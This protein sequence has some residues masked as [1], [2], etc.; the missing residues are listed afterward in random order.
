MLSLTNFISRTDGVLELS[1]AAAF[2][3]ALAPAHL[4]TSRIAAAYISVHDGCPIIEVSHFD[5]K[6][7]VRSHLLAL[8]TMERVNVCTDPFGSRVAVFQGRAIYIFAENQ[9]E[10]QFEFPEPIEQFVFSSIEALVIKSGSRLFRWEPGLREPYLLLDRIQRAHLGEHTVV[11]DEVGEVKIAQIHS[12]EIVWE[13][14]PDVQIP[15]GARACLTC[16]KY[17]LYVLAEGPHRRG[18]REI[19][20]YRKDFGISNAI[21]LFFGEVTDLIG[22]DFAAQTFPWTAG[23]VLM[24]AEIE[25]YPRAWLLGF[26]QTPQAISPESIEVFQVAP[27]VQT[28][29][30]ALVGSDISRPDQSTIRH[31]I[32]AKSKEGSWENSKLESGCFLLPK[33]LDRAHLLYARD[34]GEDYQWTIAVRNVEQIAPNVST[35]VSHLC[36]LARSDDDGVI[37]TVIQPRSHLANTAAILYVQ[38]PHRQITEGAQDTFFHQWLFLVAIKTS[39]PAVTVIGVNGPGSLGLGA[40]TREPSGH[41]SMLVTR[42][43]KAIEAVITSLHRHGIDQIGI[44]CGSLGALPVLQY[45]TVAQ[46]PIAVCFVSPIISASGALASHWQQLISAKDFLKDPPKLPRGTRL[47]LIHGEYDEFTSVEDCVGFIRRLPP[48]VSSDF[49]LLSEEGHVF[50]NSASWK[51][52]AT[53]SRVFFSRAFA[54]MAT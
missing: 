43:E 27:C 53:R 15:N 46:H 33:W 31:L 48:D 26:E 11:V 28:G 21:R 47:L 36:T 30:V 35:R 7:C 25:D 9:L 14:L 16:D 34:P 6:T 41:N 23:R 52:L 18:K 3:L 13:R 40:R 38:G 19:A 2:I 50:R 5:F 29:T 10:A 42:V 45:L 39:A 54:G 22:R 17:G 4:P 44:L 37:C 24:L 49:M 20:I 32:V 12:A 8:P 51:S 1:P